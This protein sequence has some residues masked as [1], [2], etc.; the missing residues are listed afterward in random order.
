MFLRNWDNLMLGNNFYSSTGDGEERIFGD[1]SI[2]FVGAN[3]II[4]Y[5]DS[6]NYRGLKNAD[7]K[8]IDIGA[9]MA[10]R[11]KVAGI[12]HPDLLKGEVDYD[13]YDLSYR[14]TITDT[15]KGINSNT[16]YGQ[17]TLYGPIIYNKEKKK[18]ERTVTREFKNNYSFP[19]VV[20]EIGLFLANIN[21]GHNLG[22][23]L[24]AREV[25]KQPV[26]VEPEA[27]FKAS[28][29]YECEN[30]YP[31]K[32]KYISRLY[33]FGRGLYS[34]SNNTCSIDNLN[35]SHPYILFISESPIKNL[36]ELKEK[37]DISFYKVV[38]SK[39]NTTWDT[40]DRCFVYIIKT[41]KKIKYSL[42]FER[43]MNYIFYDLNENILDIN[44]EI[45][46]S[47]DLS[48]PDYSDRETINFDLEHNKDKNEA[49]LF[50]LFEKGSIDWCNRFYELDEHNCDLI[51]YGSFYNHSASI[52]SLY[53]TY[54]PITIFFDNKIPNETGTITRHFKRDFFTT[55]TY[56]KTTFITL[57]L[58]FTTK[59]DQP[60]F[61]ITPNTEVTNNVL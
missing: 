47:L 34:T 61:T 12:Y 56:Y 46:P 13:D 18:W 59:D 28:F 55:N 21:T 15:D 54:N 43:N 37:G 9:G 38:Y 30:P 19:I 40:G 26:T 49:Y 53:W 14:Y 33:N 25:F 24:L 22:G 16:I 57:R 42:S 7:S 45:I 48:H 1:R 20:G 5:E 8:Y 52:G 2:C 39:E 17:S 29:T 23:I 27:Y 3:G 10:E 44:G 4:K 60:L 50:C 58:T 31:H 6:G 41:E 35:Y 36:N 51:R 11:G 32:N